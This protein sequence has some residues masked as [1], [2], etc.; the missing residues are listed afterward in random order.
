MLAIPFWPQG[1]L[2]L[3][4][5]SSG[6]LGKDLLPLTDEIP[7][8][9]LYVAL[10]LLPFIFET[11]ISV[12]KKD[13]DLQVKILSLRR[14]D[15]SSNFQQ[16]MK[17]HRFS[18]ESETDSDK[19]EQMCLTEAKPSIKLT[20]GTGIPEHHRFAEN[21]P[22]L[23]LLI[24][25]SSCRLS[26]LNTLSTL[27]SMWHCIILKCRFHWIAKV[28]LSSTVY[29]FRE[30]SEEAYFFGRNL[31]MMLLKVSDFTL[32]LHPNSSFTLTKNLVC[33][34]SRAKLKELL[35][36]TNIQRVARK[37]IHHCL[38][39]T[40]TAIP[41]IV[42]PV[43]EFQPPLSFYWLTVYQIYILLSSHTQPHQLFPAAF[44]KTS[45]YYTSM[46]YYLS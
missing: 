40:A 10:S 20:Y 1:A 7:A 3:I 24:K 33:S 39:C 31:S 11:L 15:Y 4:T 12:G 34:K 13:E 46:S 38:F 45:Q 23:P 43:W 9:H 32:F 26:C 8:F 18:Q 41:I 42:S 25:A 17:S 30:S 14:F 2:V 36:R 21:E 37:F 22:K 28:R 27:G 19:L 44:L 5:C 6:S 35:R 29:P 16:C